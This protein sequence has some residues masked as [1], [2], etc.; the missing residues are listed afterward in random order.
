MYI[1]QSE[2]NG[3]L[4]AERQSPTPQLEDSGQYWPYSLSHEG[5]AV[6]LVV[7]RAQASK[8]DVFIL[9]FCLNRIGSKEVELEWVFNKKVKASAVEKHVF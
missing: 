1:I 3:S 5:E 2:L 6:T 9:I 8:V 4:T 7:R